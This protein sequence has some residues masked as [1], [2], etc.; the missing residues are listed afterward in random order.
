MG[1]MGEMGEKPTALYRFFAADNRLLYVGI[2]HRLNGRL[3][4]HKR[5]KPWQEVARIELEHYPTREQA[6][7][8]E[9]RA[10]KSEKP[11][12]NVVH[13]GGGK[14]KGWVRLPE[15]GGWYAPAR[16]ISAPFMHVSCPFHGRR[17]DSR[18][19]VNRWDDR[20]GVSPRVIRDGEAWKAWG[21]LVLLECPDC[22]YP[23]S[24]P[25]QLGV[26]KQIGR[27]GGGFVPGGFA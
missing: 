17:P 11:A 15:R 21:W 5:D 8:A 4:A 22:G 23:H 25:A 10:I 13:S 12:W 7:A 20:F 18:P 6:L 1:D 24:S 19:Y 14:P 9:E 27:L 2:T 3:S 26:V 16:E